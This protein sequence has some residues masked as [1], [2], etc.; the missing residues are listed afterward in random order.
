[1]LLAILSDFKSGSNCISECPE[2]YPMCFW[3]LSLTSCFAFS[4]PIIL[5]FLCPI[6]IFISPFYYAFWKF[7]Q[8]VVTFV[9]FPTVLRDRSDCIGWSKIQTKQYLEVFQST[10]YHLNWL[11]SW[12]SV[13]LKTNFTLF[14]RVVWN[15]LVDSVKV[16]YCRCIW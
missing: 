7:H 10:V 6:F 14:A 16:E 12:V 2:V 1:M 11:L 5:Q 8:L 9:L 15:L 13:L 4:T 3:K